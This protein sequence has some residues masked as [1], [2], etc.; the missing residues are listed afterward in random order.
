MKDFD[1]AVLLLSRTTG[2][3]KLYKLVGGVFDVLAGIAKKTKN[4]NYNIF[5]AI[6]P[7]IIHARSLLRLGKFLEEFPRMVMLVRIMRAQGIDKTERK[8]II[9]LVRCML[10]F[11]WIFG[12]NIAFLAKYGI[13][14]GDP[15]DLWEFGKTCQ[16]WGFATCMILDV[17]DFRGGVI[18][19][20]YDSVA[21]KKMVI[22]SIHAFLAHFADLMETMPQVGYFSESW[23]PSRIV[24]GLLT[25]FSAGMT[26]RMNWK[27]AKYGDLE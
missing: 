25:C 4:P 26:T 17:F 15:V 24:C 1:A 18:R 12:D 9:A 6:P 19:W 27:K 11:L 8:N 10:N 5:S 14:N 21:S 23:K 3:D 20:E 2:R 13:I 7:A 16:F 22:L